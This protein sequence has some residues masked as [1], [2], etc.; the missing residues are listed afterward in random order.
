MAGIAALAAGL[1]LPLA[2]QRWE[3]FTTPAPLKSG[4][5]LIIGFMGGR[6]RWD[7]STRAV[8]KLALS[9]RDKK[10]PGVYVETVENRKRD[11]ALRLVERAFDADGDGALG[12][13]ERSAARVIL[14]G[15][16]FGGAAV[17]K[18]AR[19]LEAQGIPVILAVQVDSVGRGDAVIPP[20]VAR[21]ANLYQRDGWFIRGEAEI[22]AA[23]PARTKILGNF[24]YDYSR[25]EID[26]SAEPWHKKIFR[27]AHAKMEHDPEVWSRVEEL[28]LEAM[29]GR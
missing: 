26:L 23:D 24:L 6:D 9:L 29:A 12:E 19:Q 27:E 28:I 11:L 22:R 25:R 7:N 15:H 2:A 1:T 21:A 10:L 20:N 16:S 18:F 13:A 8:R 5:T 17:V 3:D 4:D 14:Y